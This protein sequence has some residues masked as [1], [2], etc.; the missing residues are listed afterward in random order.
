[1]FFWFVAFS[2][3]VVLAVFDSPAMDYRTVILGSVLPV[4][5]VVVGRP[6]VLHTLLGSAAVLVLVVLATR[7]RRL[8]ARRLVGL[9]IGLFLHRVADGT[10]Y[11]AVFFLAGENDGRV[12]PANSRKMTARLQAATASGRPILA[13]FSAASGHGSG[14]ALTERLAQKADVLAFLFDQLEMKAPAA[15]R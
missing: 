1:M 9:P 6:F 14:T 13:R 5:E 11:P 4:V 7:G 10:R 2:V 3:L 12:N 15:P 8:S